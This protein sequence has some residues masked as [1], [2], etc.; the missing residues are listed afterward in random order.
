M[1]SDEYIGTRFRSPRREARSIGTQPSNL[2]SVPYGP[3]GSPIGT[4]NDTPRGHRSTVPLP[5]AA[6]PCATPSS[7]YRETPQSRTPAVRRRRTTGR[8]RTRSPR[9]PRPPA[10]LAGSGRTAP[11]TSSPP[12]TVPPPRRRCSRCAPSPSRGRRSPPGRSRRRPVPT[13][14]RVPLL[15]DLRQPRRGAVPPEPR[16]GQSPC[17]T[18]RLQPRP[19]RP[20]SEITRSSSPAGDTAAKGRRRPARHPWPP[21][22]TGSA[23]PPRPTRAHYVHTP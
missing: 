22:S 2:D 23:W 6:R 3:R 21:S 5:G 10:A 9:P 1:R 12:R 16:D 19:T 20:V 4:G 13:C 14:L 18:G 17:G 15:P 8:H 7:L 11:G